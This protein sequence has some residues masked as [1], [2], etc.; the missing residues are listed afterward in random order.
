MRKILEMLAGGLAAALFASM[1]SAQGGPPDAGG[2]TLQPIQLP[3]A[4]TAQAANDNA[5]S[6]MSGQFGETTRSLLALQVGGRSAGN[7]LPMQEPVAQ[8]A[9]ERYLR[10]FQ[11]NLPQWFGERVRTEGSGAGR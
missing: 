1:A 9:W 8:A 10:S 3:P 5:L 6:G 4:A 2:A 11:R 7:P